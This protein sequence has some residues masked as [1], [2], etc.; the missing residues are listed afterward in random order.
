MPGASSRKGRRSRRARDGG[1]LDPGTDARTLADM[2]KVSQQAIGHIDCA[3]PM[4]DQ[5]QAQRNAR[6]RPV[7]PHSA[8]IVAPAAPVSVRHA[9]V[10]PP[11]PRR[12][13][14]RI[15]R[16]HLRLSRR[17]GATHCPSDFPHDLHADVARSARRI[18]A[19][20]VYAV[21]VGQRKEPAR[22]SFQP[23]Q[24]H[25]R[26]RERNIAQR[27]M[28][29]IAARSDRLTASALCPSAC[30]STSGKKCTP[31]TSI[32]VEAA[33]SHSGVR[34]SNAASS[35]TASVVWRGARVK[36]REIRSNSD[37]TG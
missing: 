26:Q 11:P 7:Q 34:V 2:R 10:Q 13:D 30:G 1:I 3:V 15:P 8:M 9:G 6:R 18:A 25:L 23:L 12:R 28:A 32:S 37:N 19:D 21:L 24:V 33:N 27:G 20:Q 4:C 5:F 16:Y 29:P 14:R 36:K 17:R 31:S 35:P 22:K